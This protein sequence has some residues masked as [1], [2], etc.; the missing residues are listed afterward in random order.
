MCEN[1]I[2]F[3]SV[4]RLQNYRYVI[5]QYI[6]EIKHFNVLLQHNTKQFIS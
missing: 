6:R 4:F 2:T 1:Y 5:I 3:V